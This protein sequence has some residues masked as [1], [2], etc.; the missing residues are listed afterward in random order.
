MARGHVLG[1]GMGDG[2]IRRIWLTRQEEPKP[3]PKKKRK[4]P[5]KSDCPQCEH[6]RLWARLPF[7]E[8]HREY[9]EE[10]DVMKSA[11]LAPRGGKL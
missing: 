1:N 2:F 9:Y 5:G 11:G 6:N 10:I 3:K 8:D 4:T 7:C